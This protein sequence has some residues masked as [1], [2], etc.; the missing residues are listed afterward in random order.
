MG[1]TPYYIIYRENNIFELE[2]TNRIPII[3]VQILYIFN[4]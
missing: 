4:H 3:G 2:V 1:N